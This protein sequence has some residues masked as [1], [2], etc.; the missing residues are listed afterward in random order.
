MDIVI[1]IQMSN[2]KS[3]F[4]GDALETKYVQHQSSLLVSSSFL[5]LY[6][7]FFFND[8]VGDTRPLKVKVEGDEEDGPPSISLRVFMLVGV[9]VNGSSSLL[10]E[11]TPS[12]SFSSSKH[13]FVS[14]LD[15]FDCAVGDKAVG[16]NGV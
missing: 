6:L 5:D 15:W 2:T 3:N 9:G 11:F 7:L 1:F 14:M 4:L 8:V 13:S 10:N 12:S 16:D